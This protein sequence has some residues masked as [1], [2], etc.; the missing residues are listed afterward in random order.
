MD[1]KWPENSHVPPFQGEAYV[2]IKQ[3]TL[4]S[5]HQKNFIAVMIMLHRHIMLFHIP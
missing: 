1:V 4:S 3:I 2:I 5:Q